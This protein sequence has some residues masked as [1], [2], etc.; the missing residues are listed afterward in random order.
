M[1]ITVRTVL[2]VTVAVLCPPLAVLLKIGWKMDVLINVVFTILGYI[3]GK[4]Y[5]LVCLSLLAS[6]ARLA[7]RYTRFIYCFR[8]CQYLTGFT[9]CSKAFIDV[10]V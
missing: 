7:R 5:Y 10:F 8:Y 3:P 9:F 1:T 2:K 6:Y 4:Q